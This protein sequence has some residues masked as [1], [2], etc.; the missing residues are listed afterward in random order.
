MNRQNNKEQ[1]GFRYECNEQSKEIAN[2]TKAILNTI[3]GWHLIQLFIRMKKTN[4]D[5][6]NIDNK[7]TLIQETDWGKYIAHSENCYGEQQTMKQ[8]SEGVARIMKSF[9]LSYEYVDVYTY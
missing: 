5:M 4:C 7:Y 2:A 1:N 8:H 9:A 6:E 3:I